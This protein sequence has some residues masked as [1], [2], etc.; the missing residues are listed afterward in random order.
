[1]PAM[2]TLA[3]ALA[4]RSHAPAVI[5][6]GGGMEL[7]R[8]QL[9]HQVQALGSTLSSA[10]LQAGNVVSMALPNTV[11][12]KTCLGHSHAVFAP[13]AGPT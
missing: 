2:Q 9:Q 8:A 5:V 1:M 4:G 7:S 6:A 12:C 11:S 10:N 13:M 3:C